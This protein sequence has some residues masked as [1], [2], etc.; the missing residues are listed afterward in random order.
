MQTGQGPNS[1]F[2]VVGNVL[3]GDSGEEGT[4]L[5]YN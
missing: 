5:R 2:G 4:I 1:K 3:A